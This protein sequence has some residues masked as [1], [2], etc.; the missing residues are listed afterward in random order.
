LQIALFIFYLFVCSYFISTIPLFKNTPIAASKIIALFIIK[1][2]AGVA[3]ALFYTLPKNYKG[4][5]TWRFYHLSLG[6]TDW[7]LKNPVAFFKDLFIHG[8]HN[9]GNL[10]AGENSYWNDLKSNVLVKLMA[11]M[12][13]I[14]FKSYYTNI[15]LFNFLFLFG[16]AAL[17]K[18]L[19]PLYPNK[20]NLLIVAIFLLPSTL[21]WCSGIHK[22]GLIL[23]ATGLLLYYFYSSITSHFTLKNS[24]LILLC[25]ILI[26]SLRNYVAFALLPALFA[27]ALSEKFPTKRGLIFSA[28]YLLG[29]ILFFITPFIFPA[30]NFPAFIAE[31]Q[32][33]FLQL[34]GASAVTS[35]HLEPDFIGFLSYLPSALDMAFFRPHLTEIKNISYIPAVAEVFLFLALFI[36]SLFLFIKKP[37]VPPAII[38]FFIFFGFS[39]MVL[40]GFTIT[41][42]GAI[43]RYRS[44]ALP[45]FVTAVICTINF[46]KSKHIIKT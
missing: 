22:D 31:K 27:L 36:L 24:I 3:Y 13:V 44:F 37:R 8:Y 30:L 21:F 16:L 12:N 46:T 23:S 41:F 4:S 7:L 32:N 5:D 9:S 20:K 6:E 43:V 29:I 34:S 39:L 25:F 10:F 38:L 18:L 26:F 42:S 17:L 2:L 35:K 15:I 1:I 19:I 11:M 45:F 28:V 40:A 14:T 33:E